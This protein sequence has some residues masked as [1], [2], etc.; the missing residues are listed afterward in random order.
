MNND[1]KIRN[2]INNEKDNVKY[3]VSVVVSMQ[4]CEDKAIMLQYACVTHM[5]LAIRLSICRL[6]YGY[7]L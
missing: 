7:I 5:T 1:E 4:G 2:R 6:Y 3:M